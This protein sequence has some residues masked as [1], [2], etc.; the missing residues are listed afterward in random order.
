MPHQAS[1]PRR[2]NAPSS[3]RPARPAPPPGNRMAELKRQRRDIQDR[4]TSN[5]RR[6]RSLRP[7]AGRRAT[8]TPSSAP[9]PTPTPTTLR[10]T[11]TPD[12]TAFQ[13]RIDV[14]QA[15]VQRD[16]PAAVKA[17]GFKLPAAK[18]V[19]T[20]GGVGGARVLGR[21]AG[22]NVNVQPLQALQSAAR[23]VRVVPRPSTV[24]AAGVESSTTETLK[25]TVRHEAAH[26]VLSSQGQPIA[27]HHE[28]IRAASYPRSGRGVQFGQLEAERVARKVG[29]PEQKTRAAR[30]RERLRRTDI[31]AGFKPVAKP[32]STLAP[33][34]I[35]APAPPKLISPRSRPSRAA[36]S[37]TLDRRRAARRAQ[38]GK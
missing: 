17:K 1:R 29:T 36:R 7:R 6:M 33:P 8:P 25:K 19:Q 28:T 35:R 22:I 15:A 32:T 21:A 38:R 34:I 24:I 23:F 4:M 27:K 18:A 5:L 20:I 2:R 26:Q 3:S 13:R 11:P 31:R 37:R 12:L 16:L 9:S 10:A 30:G 14:A